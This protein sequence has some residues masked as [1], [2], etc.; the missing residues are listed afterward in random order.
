[1]VKLRRCYKTWFNSD[2]DALTYIMNDLIWHAQFMSVCFNGR[3]MSDQSTLWQ[4]WQICYQLECSRWT[5]ARKRKATGR[6]KHE[7]TCDR[8]SKTLKENQICQNICENLKMPENMLR[9]R[10][11]NLQVSRNVQAYTRFIYDVFSKNN[12]EK[13]RR[14]DIIREQESHIKTEWHRCERNEE[15]K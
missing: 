12:R 9:P 10:C 6:M 4:T 11:M 8:C 5:K 2:A 14:K 7:R 1:M 13:L 3:T 15:H